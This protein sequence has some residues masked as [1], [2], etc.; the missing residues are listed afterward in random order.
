MILLEIE[1]EDSII[2]I[3]VRIQH[4]DVSRIN[5]ETLGSLFEGELDLIIQQDLI[6]INH[7]LLFYWSIWLRE[8]LTQ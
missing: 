4:F 2:D 1:L 5:L 7:N 3:L 6:T 8:K